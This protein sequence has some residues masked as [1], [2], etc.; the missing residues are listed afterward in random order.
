MKKIY[1]Y[2]EKLA[3]NNKVDK[4]KNDI[5]CMTHIGKLILETYDRTKITKKNNGIWLDFNNVCNS[6]VAKIDKHLKSLEDTQSESP[7]E[8]I[9]KI[10]H[11]SSEPIDI[12]T[13]SP[14]LSNH[15]KSLMKYSKMN[16]NKSSDI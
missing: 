11:T 5:Q 4:H 8:V 1:T 13:K 7:T 10:K 12:D 15:E 2:N 6:T 14:K 9:D 3:I 16:E